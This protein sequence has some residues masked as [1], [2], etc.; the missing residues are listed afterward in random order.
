MKRNLKKYLAA[1]FAAALMLLCSGCAEETTQEYAWVLATASPEDTVTQIYAEKFAE[2]VERLSDG[3]MRIE[4][5]ANSSL[6]GDTELIECCMTGDIPFVVQNTAPQVSYLPRLCLFDLPCVFDSIDELHE[7]LD[8]EQFMEK[9]NEIYA[10]KGLELLGMSDQDFRVM[11]SNVKVESLEDFSGIK[12]RT[13]ENSYHMAFWKA[14]GANPTPM[15][16]SEVYIG[17][18]QNT[19]DAQENPY[20][21]I[22]SNKFYEQQDYIIQTNHL[23]H[24]LSLIVSEGFMESL[25]EDEQ[26]IIR[27]AAATACAYARE[28]AQ[29]RVADRIAICE[30]GGAEIVEISDELRAQMREASAELYEEIRTVVADDDLYYAY[31]GA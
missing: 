4:V 13:M 9:I 27:E 19:I 26:A 23:P 17:L 18:Q 6:G 16:F 25:E 15:S 24:L 30:E 20:E 2:E 31:I 14:I 10:E 28:Q 8:D 3:A 29:E 7:V 5:Y 1:A 11:T 21:V 12:I 22:V